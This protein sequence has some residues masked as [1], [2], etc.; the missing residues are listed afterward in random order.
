MKIKNKKILVSIIVILIAAIGLI[1]YKISINNK[2]VQGMKQYKVI[3]TD[4]ENTFN[5]EFRIKTE[6]TSLG[7]DLD[8]RDLIEA[9]KGPYGRFVTVVHGK[10]ADQGKQQWWQLI[11]NGEAASTAI[12]DVMIHNGDEVRLILTTGW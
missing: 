8:N 9:E 10:T 3:V 4:T 6:E 7:K 5:D 2:A 11:V 12:D 1:G